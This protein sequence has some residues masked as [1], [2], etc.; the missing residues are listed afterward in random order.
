[1]KKVPVAALKASLAAHLAKVKAGRSLVITDRGRPVAIL[2]PVAW[3]LDQDETLKALVLAGQVTPASD[4]LPAAFFQMPRIQD[5]KSKIRT[6][7]DEER[8]SGW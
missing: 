8:R 6:F 7:L 5:P 1:M 4:E 2:E 3:D